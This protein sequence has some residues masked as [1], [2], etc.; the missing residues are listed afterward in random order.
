VHRLRD[1][2]IPNADFPPSVRVYAGGGPPQGVDFLTQ[3][4]ATFPWLVLAVLVFTYLLLMRAFRSVLLPLK[5]VLLNLLSVAASYGMLV[6]FFKWVS[7]STCS[8]STS[9]LRS[10]GGSRSSCSRCCSGSRWTTRSSC[11]AYA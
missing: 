10:R 8:A 5:A 7:A 1:H 4:Y 6:V 2:L 3:S 9:S 11:L